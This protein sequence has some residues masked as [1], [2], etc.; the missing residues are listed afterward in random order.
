MPEIST[1]S[2]SKYTRKS[3]RS[4]KNKYKTAIDIYN[5]LA[6]DKDI[7]ILLDH[8]YI[9]YKQKQSIVKDFIGIKEIAFNTFNINTATMGFVE[10]FVLIIKSN[11]LI[12]DYDE[13]TKWNDKRIIIWDKTLKLDRLFCSGIAN[14]NTERLK[15][16]L[17]HRKFQ[18]Y[19]QCVQIINLHSKIG[20]INEEYWI[21]SV[22]IHYIL[23]Q[24]LLIK[25]V[26]L[27][28]FTIKEIATYATGLCLNC[29]WCDDCYCI[30]PETTINHSQLAAIDYHRTDVNELF[31]SAYLN[32]NS[33]FYICHKCMPYALKEA[34]KCINCGS[35][36]INK[37][38]IY[39]CVDEYELYEDGYDYQYL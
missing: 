12:W 11:K 17:K 38:C 20:F 13:K 10:Y 9:G 14:Q 31:G 35:P 22:N 15:T 25:S 27:D 5:K 6:N 36:V 30:D 28:S 33:N 4:K 19:D 1:H 7:G 23:V 2:N 29:Y 3:K 39:D 18:P 34:E 32:D 21:Q 37:R 24:C 26:N 8:V 16:F